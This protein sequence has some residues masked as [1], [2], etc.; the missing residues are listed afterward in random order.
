MHS[1]PK[2]FGDECVRGDPPFRSALDFSVAHTAVPFGLP[3]SENIRSAP[4]EARW[5]L[6]DGTSSQVRQ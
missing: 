1:C 3:T 5:H 4:E 6:P 2:I